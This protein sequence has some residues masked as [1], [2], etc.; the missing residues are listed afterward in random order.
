MTTLESTVLQGK[1][2]K[3]DIED[4]RQRIAA[5]E[6]R[7]QPPEHVSELEL[8][9]LDDGPSHVSASPSPSRP[10]PSQSSTSAR[11]ELFPPDSHNGS[12]STGHQSND[13][14][15]PRSCRPAQAAATPGQRA[16][17]RPA[18]AAAILPGR[19]A[20]AAATSLGRADRQNPK[21]ISGTTP[22]TTTSES[23]AET[24]ATRATFPY[25]ARNQSQSPGALA[26]GLQPPPPQPAGSTGVHRGRLHRPPASL[27]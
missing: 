13:S 15:S 25:L 9:S 5:I 10:S 21:D 17:G 6:R 18:P 22:S 1:P 23:T 4:A 7:S 2:S 11:K 27:S 20:Q 3:Q 19:P 14:P 24:C 26:L 12:Q 16:P 8:D